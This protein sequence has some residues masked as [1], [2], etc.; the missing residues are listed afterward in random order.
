MQVQV[1]LFHKMYLIKHSI[2]LFS[3]CSILFLLQFAAFKIKFVE[4]FVHAKDKTHLNHF[5]KRLYFQEYACHFLHWREH[6]LPFAIVTDLF[7]DFFV[8]R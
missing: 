1:K 4:K 5:L 3:H 7:H 2:Y 8:T 6:P